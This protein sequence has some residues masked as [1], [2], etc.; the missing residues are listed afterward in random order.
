MKFVK[1]CSCH[2][3]IIIENSSLIKKNLAGYLEELFYYFIF[4]DD[5]TR[6]D[7]P[8]NAIV[9]LYQVSYIPVFLLFR[10]VEFS[11][12]YFYTSETRGLKQLSFLNA[13]SSIF[14]Q[15]LFMVHL[16]FG[17]SPSILT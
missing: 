12:I 16:I 2:Y 17:R 11:A 7:Y 5:R 1:F 13:F 6:T 3:G 9:M 14:L 4:G 8:Y 15:L 10:S